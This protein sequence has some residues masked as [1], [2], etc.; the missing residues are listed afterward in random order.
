MDFDDDLDAL[1]QLEEQVQEE[2]YEPDDY[3]DI[4]E[5]EDDDPSSSDHHHH[6]NKGANEKPTAMTALNNSIPK[7]TSTSSSSR[8][9]VTKNIQT[10]LSSHELA[11]EL[12][13][14]RKELGQNKDVGAQSFVQLSAA[15][16]SLEPLFRKVNEECISRCLLSRPEM[17]RSHVTCVLNN[18][19]R[20]FLNLRPSPRVYSENS[21]R[22]P[23][24]TN[25]LSKPMTELLHEAQAMEVQ[26][27]VHHHPLRHSNTL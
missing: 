20:V 11:L 22:V 26:V 17:N 7:Q 12:Q 13:A 8:T 16:V 27:R 19:S 1:M 23:F 3:Q 25:L 15:F 21:H 24:G 2:Q 10:K 14:M 9:T 4:E 5:P 18:G 6:N